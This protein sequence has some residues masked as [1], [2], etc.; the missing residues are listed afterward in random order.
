MDWSKAS[1]T[2]VA[3]DCFV[4]PHMREEVPDPVETWCLREEGYLEEDTSQI[5]MGRG[6]ELWEG[7]QGGN[8]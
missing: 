8:I 1:G 3:E 4:C 5:Q 6:E 7:G 2:Y